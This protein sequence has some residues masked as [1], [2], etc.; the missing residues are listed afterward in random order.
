M[1]KLETLNDLLVHEIK[2]L[3]SAENQ[4]LT[5]LPKMAKAATS[6]ALQEAFEEHLEQTKEHVKRLERA[7]E[8]LD[9]SPRGKACKAMQGLIEEGEETIRED[10]ED[11]IR[12][13]ALIGAAQKVEHYEIAG[14]GTVVAFAERLGLEEVAEILRTT[15]DE[16]SETDRKLTSLS[17]SLNAEAEVA[18][19]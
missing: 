6:S 8:Q 7:M 16:E 1:S 19:E 13:A 15:L 11:S 5:A 2:D 14:Y 9:G 3:Y 4:L 10:A 17:E 18:K 12:D